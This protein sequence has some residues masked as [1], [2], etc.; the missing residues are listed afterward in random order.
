MPVSLLPSVAHDIIQLMFDEKVLSEREG[1]LLLLVI[2]DEA[3]N[4]LLRSQMM[5]KIIQRL[6]RDE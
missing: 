3:I 4:P 2:T 6:D 1:N 5:K